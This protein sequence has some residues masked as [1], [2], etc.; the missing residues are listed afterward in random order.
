MEFGRLPGVEWADKEDAE[1]DIVYRFCQVGVRDTGMDW[2]ATCGNMLS[3]VAYS[4]LSTPLI[5]YTTLF[6]RSKS[7][8]KPPSG[9]PLLF[10]IRILSAS[11]GR[12][13]NVRIPID[14]VTLQVWDNPDDENGI[15]IAGVPGRGI[16]IE[17]EMPLDDTG[18]SVGGL[19][20]GNVVDSIDIDGV[21]VCFVLLSP[22]SI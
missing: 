16:P 15:E 21:D 17:L 8:P 6:T 9:K 7:L 1:W 19:V 22:L 13:M 20:T 11:N 10:P 12:I 3:A 2:S 5:P 4:T 18:D 14:P